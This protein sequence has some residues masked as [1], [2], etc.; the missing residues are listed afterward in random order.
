MLTLDLDDFMFELQDG[1]IKHVGA[2]TTAATAKLYHVERA[3]ARAFGDSQVKLA[4]ADDEGN[5]IEVA[6]DPDAANSVVSD[7]ERL[8]KEDS[9]FE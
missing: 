3:E 4:F 5:E 8:R 6:L 2:P 9:V 1:T 7:V